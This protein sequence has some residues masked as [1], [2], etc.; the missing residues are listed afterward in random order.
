MG[1]A[2]EA[3]QFINEIFGY[4]EGTHHFT[5]LV[6]CDITD[7][8]LAALEDIWNEREMRIQ[9]TSSKNSSFLRGFWTIKLKI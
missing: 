7:R 9:G 8:K 1:I 2:A 5:G 6:D 4:Q 3:K